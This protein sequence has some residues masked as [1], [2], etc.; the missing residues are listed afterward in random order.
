MRVTP[1]VLGL[2][3]ESTLVCTVWAGGVVS[4]GWGSVRSSDRSPEGLPGASGNGGALQAEEGLAI[5][6]RGS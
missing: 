6:C 5:S 2:L 3:S 4:S 1:E